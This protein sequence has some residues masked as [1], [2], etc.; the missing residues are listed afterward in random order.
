[1]EGVVREVCLGISFIEGMEM[2]DETTI[3]FAYVLGFVLGIILASCI[4]IGAFVLYTASENTSRLPEY[5]ESE[6][7]ILFSPDGGCLEEM[8]YWLDSANNTVYSMIYSFTT[9]ELGDAFVDAY[10]RSI[11]VKVIFEPSQITKYSEYSKLVEA[12]IP[13]ANRISE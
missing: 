12:G 8:L 2:R 10:N 4:G 9:D 3:R 13:V 11:D 7:S 5:G 6:M 1:M